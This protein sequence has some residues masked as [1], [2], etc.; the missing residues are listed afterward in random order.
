MKKLITLLLVITSFAAF[1]QRRTC[2]TMDI[3]HKR[4]E[5][6]PEFAMRHQEMMDFIYNPNNPQ[7][8]FRQPNAPSI[9][10]TIPVVFHVLYSNA[11]QNI[12]DAQI[13]SQLT[14]LNNDYRK[15][16]ANFNTAVPAAFRP[17]AADM[18]IV[19]CKATRTPTGVATTGITR[20]S[21]STS[22]DLETQYYENAGEPA[23]DTTKYLNIWIGQFPTGSDILGFANLPETGVVGS[24]FDGL[25]IG[26][27]Y[28]GTTGTATAPF[29]YGRTATHEIGHYL[30]LLHPWGD[31]GVACGNPYIDPQTPSNDDRVSDTPE[32]RRWYFGCP[33]FPTNTYSCATTANGSMFMNYMDYVDDACMG[34]FSN[35]QKVVVQ[36]TLAGP[37]LSLLSSNGCTSLG[38]NEVAAIKA[39]AVYP[40]PAS[41]YFMI[42]SPQVDID[43][44]EIF[45]TVG[46]LV[47][48]QKLAQANNVINIED[49]ASGTYYLRIYNA[50]E[51]LKSDKI[52]KK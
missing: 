11:T 41:K 50:G 27:Q 46:Q 25:C 22:F 42:T 8:L 21:V 49:L 3:L 15:L 23:W 4:M 29:N 45:N 12:S 40:N 17:L 19:F 9:V 13:N 7:T 26:N 39:I 20:K 16:N 1:S 5:T 33:T 38:L 36:N 10:V 31:D 44:V 51:F 52:I 30:G 47:K 48:T 6:D 35:G 37:R 43:E 34:M 24:S 2:A 32:T 28:F 18:E 14:V